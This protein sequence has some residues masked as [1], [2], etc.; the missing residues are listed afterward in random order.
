M[1]LK[2]SWLTSDQKK[3][4]AR[5]SR[6]STRFVKSDIKTNSETV[7]LSTY[8]PVERVKYRA[9][10]VIPKLYLSWNIDE[11][12]VTV[13]IPSS[14]QPGDSC[15]ADICRYCTISDG[16]TFNLWTFP[17]Y[18]VYQISIVLDHLSINSD[19]I[20]NDLCVSILVSI[21]LI[22]THFSGVGRQFIYHDI[23]C[24]HNLHINLPSPRW[25]R[26]NL[27]CG[28]ECL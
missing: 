22:W 26:K 2:S 8:D 20:E 9:I 13:P 5:S 25:V 12:F 21:F 14:P 18:L 15:W 27:I 16:E 24:F 3:R 19:W 4:Q 17:K 6:N 10:V 11:N 28:P 23:S 1:F 7:T